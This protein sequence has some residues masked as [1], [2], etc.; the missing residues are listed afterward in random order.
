MTINNQERKYLIES[1]IFAL[2]WFLLLVPFLLRRGIENANPYLQFL[3]F[4][5]GIFIFLQIFLKSR[6]L[7]SGINFKNK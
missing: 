2:F 5:I 3:I 6:A 7:K 4:N 1:I